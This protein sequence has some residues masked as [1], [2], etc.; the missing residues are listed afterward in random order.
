[1]KDLDLSR[2]EMLGVASAA[3]IAVGLAGAAQAATAAS[4][5]KASGQAL[6][7]VGRLPDPLAG[8]MRWA[9][10]GLGNYAVA[11]M[12]PRFAQTEHARITAFVSGDA[13]KAAD[14]GARYGVSKFYNYDNFDAIAQDDQIDCVYIALPVGLHA[15]YTIRALKA[16]KH[17]LC[18]KPMANT[19][20][21][22]RAMIAAA[23]A[24]NRQLGVAYRVH[25]DPFNIDV[26]RRLATGEI[27]DIRWIGADNHFNADPSF[28]PHKWRLSKSLGG[29]G[30][31]F[32][33]G[34]YGL[35]GALMYLGDV[36]PLDV[37]AVY[38]TPPGDA[39]F[40][41]VEGGLQY[42]MRMANGAMVHGSTSYYTFSVNRQSLVGTSGSMAM[43]PANGYDHNYLRIKKA[44]S[45]DLIVDSIGSVPQFAGQIDGFCLAAKA[46]TPHRTPG[47]MGLRDITLI[48]AIYRSADAGGQVV[49]L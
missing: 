22:C 47:E 44:G 33:Y 42:R 49:K 37:S 21:E 2:R 38:T 43:E 24:A 11:Q 34:I 41:E 46:N 35:N 25:F 13:A 15:E 3:G 40:A 14:L 48:E 9:I 18:E 10:V 29:G 19:S 23:K 4:A 32:D 27:G 5:P 30:P 31:M 7:G 8:R 28:P 45:A 16:G 26:K 20:A 39:R 17:V 6:A 1:M 12:I 36:A